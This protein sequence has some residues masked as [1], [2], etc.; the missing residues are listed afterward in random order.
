MQLVDTVKKHLI[1]IKTRFLQSYQTNTPNDKIVAWL[2]KPDSINLSKHWQNKILDMDDIVIGS[3]PHSISLKWLGTDNEDTFNSLQP[4]GKHWKFT[5]DNVNYTL[6]SFGY[7]GD[8]P[9][10][11]SDF[12]VLVLGDSHTFG[13][14]LDDN[15]VWPEH[16][17][18]LLQ[19][20]YPKC[21]IINLSVLGG[22]NDVMSRSLSCCFNIINPDCVI[23]CYTYPNRREAIWDSG[24]IWQLNMTLPN[25]MK[26]SDHDEFQSWFMTIN[27]HTDYYNWMKNHKF[28]QAICKNTILIESQVSQMAIIQKQL[29]TTLQYNDVA[30][31]CKHFGPTVHL[32]FAKNLYNKFCTRQSNHKSVK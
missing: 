9:K 24:N 22:S 4:Q 3:N 8:E 5:K 21:K 25:G 12:T 16:F 30:R 13:C 28:I 23:V 11:E 10:A 19:Q 1:K 6:N 32:E 2:N 14:G 7:R 26:K 20:Q 31:D 18:R 15:D 17:K 27:E 29:G